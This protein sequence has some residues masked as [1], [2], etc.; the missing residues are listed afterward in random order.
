[1]SLSLS[2]YNVRNIL[3]KYGLDI[4]ETQEFQEAFQQEHHYNTTVAEH[5]VNVAVIGIMICLLLS[6]IHVEMDMR[7]VVCAS[8]C[9]DLGIMGRE[10]KY[11]NEI[12]CCWQHPLDSVE[13]AKKI[14]PDADWK[15][16]NCIETHMWPVRPGCPKSME[17]FVITLADKGA[18]VMECAH[19]GEPYH[20]R[21]IVVRY[22]VI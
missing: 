5:S 10:T 11:R 19:R 13:V 17:A 15:T 12:Q 4:M 2:Y 9:H 7:M 16:L 21:H 8:L 6:R 18:A 22:A 20:C 1:M 3:L 14:L